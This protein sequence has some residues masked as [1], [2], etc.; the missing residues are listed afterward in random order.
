MP[1]DDTQFQLVIDGE[2]EAN[3][4]PTWEQIAVALGNLD[5]FHRTF[6]ILG[7]KDKDYVQAFGCRESMTIEWRTYDRDHYSHDVL[8][9][10]GI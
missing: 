1:S 6:V 8:G 7:K 10:R 5:G 3:G 2:P 4:D 9:R